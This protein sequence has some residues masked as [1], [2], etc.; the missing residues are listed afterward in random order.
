MNDYIIAVDRDGQPY[1]AHAW[2]RGANGQH[3]YIAK[4][5]EGAKARYFYTQ[6]QLR[7][8]Q[9]GARQG[10]QNTANKA[11]E[12]ASDAVGR[13]RENST[14][15]N[16]GNQ[17]R[18][19]KQAHQ[20]SK[21]SDPQKAKWGKEGYESNN[22]LGG[23]AYKAQQKAKETVKSTSDRMKEEF[24][25]KKAEKEAKVNAKKET[26]IQA[27]KQAVN[28][29][30]FDLKENY[31]ALDRRDKIDERV[32]KI[33]H[34]EATED[35]V[36]DQVK[37]YKITRDIEQARKDY[38]NF[39]ISAKEFNDVLDKAEKDLDGIEKK[40]SN[41]TDNKPNS[42]NKSKFSEYT[43]GDKDFDDKN[44]T[45]KNR[46]GDSDFFM[47]KRPDGSTVILEEDMKWVLPKGV[48][49]NDPAIKR[50]LTKEYKAGSNEEWVK[51][52][53]EAID[54][55]VEEANKKK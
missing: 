19:A 54:D 42:S 34:K 40:Q 43:K 41:K 15:L 1:I 32:K 55:A 27:E 5:G 47:A 23:K 12:K 39:K 4:I 36:D 3:K 46:V 45:E 29:R 33:T 52:V 18:S 11:K 49:P 2:G 9:Q 6:E 50:A 22:T 17:Y 38:Q 44:F 53:T 30:N 16:V 7:A 26:E 8:F 20:N 51:Q 25:K 35:T 28:K 14:L 13:V 10:V 48:N 21:S 31:A 37:A 24:G